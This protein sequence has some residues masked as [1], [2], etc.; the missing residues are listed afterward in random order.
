MSKPQFPY[1]R[2]YF[3]GGSLTAVRP[4]SID[5]KVHLNALGMAKM[6]KRVLYKERTFPDAQTYYQ[7]RY[8]N[9]KIYFDYLT[10]YLPGLP[11]EEKHNFAGAGAGT[12]INFGDYYIHEFFERYTP[13]GEKLGV[14]R[15]EPAPLTNVNQQVQKLIKLEK[16]YSSNNGKDKRLMVS[17]SGG[18]HNDMLSLTY[19]AGMKYKWSNLSQQ[20]LSSNMTRL[21][22]TFEAVSNVG[23][24]SVAQNILDCYKQAKMKNFIVY[25][26]LPVHQTP[27][28]LS[29]IE[30]NNIPELTKLINSMSATYDKKIR[31]KLDELKGL[32]GINITYVP[33]PTLDKSSKYATISWLNADYNR[34]GKEFILA[35][36]KAEEQK[37]LKNYLFYDPTHPSTTLHRQFAEHLSKHLKMSEPHIKKY[38][39]DLAAYHEENKASKNYSKRYRDI[40]IVD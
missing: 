11:L 28:F 16:T 17:W 13:E 6:W 29:V 15:I 20:D 3:V 37:D 1:K 38:Y 27:M 10:E 5:I 14:K 33:A 2:V 8:T 12:S 36:C 35:N 39:E 25:G 9:G 19:L 34:L 21:K 23:S 31:Q 32:K 26:C 4:I 30:K 22:E 18:A 7:G 40:A 24:T